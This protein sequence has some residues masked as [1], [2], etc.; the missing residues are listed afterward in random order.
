MTQPIRPQPQTAPETQSVVDEHTPELLTEEEI[1]RKYASRV[2]NLARRMLGN[3]AD[4]EDVTQDVF[5]QVLRNLP[6]FRGEAAFSTWLY[7]IAVNTTLT[8]RRKRAVRKAYSLAEPFQEF[9]DNGEHRRPLRRWA[10]G[11]EQLALDREAHQLIEKAIGQLPEMYRDVYVLADVEGLPN[12]DIADMLG[13]SV[14]AVK[15]RLHRARLL[16]RTLLAPY[17]EEKSA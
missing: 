5:V 6:T 3:D 8:Y 14:A 16:M 17:F 10:P 4:A 12:A 11:P 13:L 1:F 15:S 2:Y 7:R 9:A